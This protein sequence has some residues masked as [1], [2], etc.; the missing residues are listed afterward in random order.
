MNP[1]QKSAPWRKWK[2]MR[3]V[4]YIEH[5]LFSFLTTME[6]YSYNVVPL[7]NTTPV[8]YGQIRVAAILE[9]ERL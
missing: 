4:S 1:T 2:R 8:D 5:F 9:L 3:K 7:A 6:N